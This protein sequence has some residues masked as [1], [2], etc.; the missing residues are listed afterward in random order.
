MKAW[1]TGGTFAEISKSKF[2]ELQIPFPPREIQDELVESYAREQAEIDRL[3]AEIAAR[4]AR[5]RAGIDRLFGS[6]SEPRAA[7]SAAEE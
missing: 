5:Q 3:S 1:A 7:E 4:A 6:P 2:C